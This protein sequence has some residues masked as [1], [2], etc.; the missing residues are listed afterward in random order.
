VTKKIKTKSPEKVKEAP[1]AI[2]KFRFK[3]FLLVIL[4]E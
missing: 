1:M 2:L 4:Y 3:S